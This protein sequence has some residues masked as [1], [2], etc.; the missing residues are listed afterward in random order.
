MEHKSEFTIEEVAQY[1]T[2]KG[3]YCPR[4]KSPEVTQGG[5]LSYDGE[6]QCYAP[7][8]CHTCGERWDD[9]FEL[10]GLRRK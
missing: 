1:V 6:H 2:G 8:K 4:C 10:S 9:V 5:L 3:G 7:M